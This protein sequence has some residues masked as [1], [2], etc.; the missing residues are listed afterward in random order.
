MVE[1]E[2]LEEKEVAPAK[3]HL[4][5]VAAKAI[6][7]SGETEFLSIRKVGE[8]GRFKQLLTIPRTAEVVNALTDALKSV[9]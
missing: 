6:S 3:G 7:E 9:V 8:N 1:F 2:T 5:V 4:L